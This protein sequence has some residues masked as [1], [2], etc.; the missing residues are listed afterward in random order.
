MFSGYV[1]SGGR[2]GAGDLRSI[3]SR[4]FESLL[5]SAGVRVLRFHVERRL[6]QDMYDAF[7]ED[8]GKFYKALSEIFGAGAEPLMRLIARWL[9]DKGY[10][11]N[12]NPDEFV[13]LLKRGGEEAAQII[14]R[15]FKPSRQGVIDA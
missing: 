3:L 6:G 4:A 15:S 5:G 12:L 11:E 7:Y 10:M 13:S 8:P 14:R 1:G 9:S 2:G